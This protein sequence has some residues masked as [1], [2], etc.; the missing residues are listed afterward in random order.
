[1]E[2]IVAVKEHQ[3]LVLD[4]GAR[5]ACRED[6]FLLEAMKRTRSG[7]IHYGCFGGGCGVCKMKVVSGSYFAE[8]R[9]SVAHAT[10]EEQKNGIVLI[11]CV[12][13]REDMVIMGW[14][15]KNL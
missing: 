4:T 1:M 12:K 11:C 10:H 5:F 2:D 6:E 9:M 15:N 8:K 3:V 7:P 13:P 14:N